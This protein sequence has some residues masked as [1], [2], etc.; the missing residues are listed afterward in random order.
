ML[1]IRAPWPSVFC[2]EEHDAW[3]MAIAG[4][5]VECASW[6]PFPVSLLSSSPC[7]L[8]SEESLVEFVFKPLQTE[9]SKA[10]MGAK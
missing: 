10:K 8:E 2:E 1:P 4:F 3:D 6:V 7:A 9:K 5:F